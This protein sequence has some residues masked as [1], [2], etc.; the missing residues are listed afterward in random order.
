MNRQTQAVLSLLAALGWASGAWAGASGDPTEAPP[1]WVAAQP[2]APG[3]APMATGGAGPEVGVIVS[4]K[5]RRLALID[6]EVV[7]VGDQYKGSKVVAIKADKVVM[8]DAAKSLG[9]TPNVSKTKPVL[10]PVRK[11]RVVLP[12]GDVSPKAM[13]SH[14]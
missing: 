4:G 11:K 2:V 14:Q 6:G 12:A 7:K 1:V 9:A 13:G 3:A 10:V 5:S 8:E